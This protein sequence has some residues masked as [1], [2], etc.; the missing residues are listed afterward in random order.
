MRNRLREIR[1]LRGLTQAELAA[2]SGYSEGMVSRVESGELDPSEDFISALCK[3]LGVTVKEILPDGD[4]GKPGVRK[5]VL[6]EATAKRAEEIMARGGYSSLD[7]LV[8]E[9]VRRLTG[10]VQERILKWKDL[11]NGGPAQKV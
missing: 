5:V 3:S 1:K 2:K 8:A 4:G 6:P 9:A 10:D 7:E 11:E